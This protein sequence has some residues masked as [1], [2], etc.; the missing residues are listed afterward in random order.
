MNN[1]NELF[2]FYKGLLMFGV[3][4]GHFILHLLVGENND[5]NIHWILRTYDMPMFMLISG[6]FFSKSCDKYC[7]K[8]LLVNKLTTIAIPCVIWSLLYSYGKSVD[9]FYFLTAIL[10]SSISMAFIHKVVKQKTIK[11]IL[12]TLLCIFFHFINLPLWNLAYLFPFFVLGYYN[13]GFHC[14]M[15]RLYVVLAF[16][17]SLCFWNTEYTVWN[18]GSCLTSNYMM[19]PIVIFRNLIAILGG[20]SFIFLSTILF[21]TINKNSFPFKTI[22]L[23]GKE[24]LLLYIL[25]CFP[26]RVCENIMYKIVDYLG[27]NPISFNK[28]FFGYVIAPISSFFLMAILLYMISLMKKNKYTYLLCGP[29][30]QDIRKRWTN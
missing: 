30:I 27:F 13:Y 16:I 14:S 11:G 18:S 3:I 22:I 5:I 8:E 25:Q 17:T 2:D 28:Q 19:I 6:Y 10:I 20:Y 9:C 29:K 21:N 12:I 4:W 1:R 7:L 15:N 24:S 23:A 26:F